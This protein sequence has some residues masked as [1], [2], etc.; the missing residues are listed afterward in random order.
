[1]ADAHLILVGLP[2]AGKSTVGRLVAEQLGA[3]FA[4]L[5][6]EIEARAGCPISEIFTNL[7]ER[8]FRELERELTLEFGRR[9]SHVIAPGGGWITN[10]EVVALLR[11]PGRIIHL[12]VTPRTAL[13]RMGAELLTRPLLDRSD[14]LATLGRLRDERAAAYATAD[15]VIDTETLALQEL[16]DRVAELATAWGAGVG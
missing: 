3:R 13:S 7:G 5:D 8:G 15:A 1:L 9:E 4:D 16:V 2:G 11:P 12:D 6:V 10:A 14:P